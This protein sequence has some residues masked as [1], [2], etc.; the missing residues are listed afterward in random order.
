MEIIEWF[1]RW[2]HEM[3]GWGRLGRMGLLMTPKLVLGRVR[4]A[5]VTTDMPLIIDERRRDA[6]LSL[7]S[8]NGAINAQPIA[9]EKQFHLGSK[10]KLMGSSDG[11][12][13]QKAA[14]PIGARLEPT[15]D[16]ACEYVLSHNILTT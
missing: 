5:V 8:A 4:L 12:L 9:R 10:Q 11:K 3:P 16:D 15:A 2:W 1:V 6:T 13:T 14:L 7:I